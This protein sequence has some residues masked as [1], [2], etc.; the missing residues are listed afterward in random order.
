MVPSLRKMCREYN[1]Q[2]KGPKKQT[3]ELNDHVKPPCVRG[4]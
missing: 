4:P 1:L 3:V 2:D